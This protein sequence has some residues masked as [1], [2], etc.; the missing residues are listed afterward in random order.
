MKK[1]LITI[2]VFIFAAVSAYSQE[3]ASQALE[4]NAEVIDLVREGQIDKA[5]P[6]AVRVVDI[7]RKENNVRNL[8][9][10][11]ENLSQLYIMRSNSP[12][13]QASR[14][15]NDLQSAE[16]ALKEALAKARGS[17]QIALQQ[18]AELR[19][20]LASLLYKFIP[21]PANLNVSFDK[22]S[23]E[24]Y[25]GLKRAIFNE[26][27]SEARKLLEEAIA[28][29]SVKDGEDILAMALYHRAE[30]ELAVSEIETALGLYERCIALITEKYGNKSGDLVIPMRSYLIALSA[31]GQDDKAMDV[32]SEIV[33]I[34]GQTAA[35]PKDLVNLSNRSES[36]FSVGIGG[37]LERGKRSSK[38]NAELR[39]RR[40]VT[41]VVAAGGS[42]VAASIANSTLHR[43]YYEEFGSI[44]IVVLA[45]R[46]EID[47]S[48]KVIKA[49]M[50]SDDPGN[51]KAAE[52]T[53][54]GWRFRP[55]TSGGQA[56]KVT[57]YVMVSI[58]TDEKSRAG[59]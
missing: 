46:V 18:Q 21:P 9:N 2:V 52:E 6:I 12:A 11:L 17:D 15:Q 40:N 43:E 26:R 38:E 42:P 36:S 50:L 58:L 45:V 8:V 30:F 51:K 47:G 55:F 53:V 20:S 32:L 48:G 49:E 1:L 5:I 24:K 31:T 44:R 25:E 57:G 34:T 56:G 29:S 41:D 13:A 4:M 28:L 3:R 37:D 33:R 16:A 22:Q 54:L 23:R 7:Q 19:S 39:G 14:R 10:A 59:S 27:T 35:F